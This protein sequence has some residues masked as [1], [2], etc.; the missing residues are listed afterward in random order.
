LESL[1]YLERRKQQQQK[2]QQD[3]LLLSNQPAYIN[4]IN[5]IKSPAT[6]KKYSYL[7]EEYFKYLKLDLDYNNNNN[8]NNLDSLLLK[9]VKTIENEIIKYIIFLKE[10][11]G[12]AYASLNTKL[13]AILLF[14][15][16]NDVV[17]N[18][19][20]IARYLGEHIKTVKDRAYTREEIKKIVDASSLKYKIIVTLMASSGCRIGALPN[21]VL[22]NLKY[23]DEYQLY[24]ITFY[25]N[26]KDEYYSFCTPE[27]SNYI[28]EYLQF[29]ERCCEKLKPSSPLI[30][31]DF[32]QNDLLHIE[33]PKFLSLDSYQKYLRYVLVKVGIRIRTN[34]LS[35]SSSSSN[36]NK[37]RERKEISQNHGFRKFTMTT[38]SHARISPEI[39]EMLLG[40]SI[41]LGDSYYRPNVNEMLSEY[42]KVVNDLTIDPSHRLQKQVQELKQQDDYQKY[43]ID[44]KMAEKDREIEQLN[45]K[46]DVFNDLMSEFRETINFIMNNRDKSTKEKIKLLKNNT[47][48]KKELLHK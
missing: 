10:N 36:K 2:Q 20:K 26:T 5:A 32:Q 14:F 21:L 47:S 22:R 43:V 30:R 4:F 12:L 34:P 28:R 41:G 24:Q 13:A 6:K 3:H 37:K 1:D 33:N 19:K 23:Y 45:S 40:H 38:M 29:R 15:T 8:N 39:R 25:E 17:V 16:M 44:K 18:R 46:L 27:C 35:T 11:K 7:L 9:S 31:T 48:I 42:L